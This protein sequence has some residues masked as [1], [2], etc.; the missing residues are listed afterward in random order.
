[1]GEGDGMKGFKYIEGRLKMEN[2]YGKLL[3]EFGIVFIVIAYSGSLIKLKRH[4]NKNYMPIS[5]K[6]I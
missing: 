6:E 5:Y 1:M 3:K 2:G 4:F